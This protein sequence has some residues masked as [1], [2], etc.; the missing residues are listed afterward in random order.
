MHRARCRVF[1]PRVRNVPLKMSE[2]RRIAQLESKLEDTTELL[3]L[4]QNEALAYR[5]LAE[6]M[7]EGDVTHETARMA[8]AIADP[9]KIEELKE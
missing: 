1:V 8:L 2:D 3:H 7:V 4:W 5:Q 6:A 9:K